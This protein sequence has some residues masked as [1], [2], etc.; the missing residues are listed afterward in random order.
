MNAR[1]RRA[2]AT[3]RERRRPEH[4]GPA[5][6]G[7]LDG[8]GL[9]LATRYSHNPMTLLEALELPDEPPNI[10]VRRQNS[11]GSWGVEMITRTEWERRRPKEMDQ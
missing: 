2:R 8:F 9:F 11:D 10:P 4:D 3:L 1:A 6:L 7:R 5:L